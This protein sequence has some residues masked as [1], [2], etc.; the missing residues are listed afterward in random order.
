MPRRLPPA[1]QRIPDRGMMAAQ[2]RLG[3]G[4][5]R[6]VGKPALIRIHPPPEGKVVEDADRLPIGMDTQ[7]HRLPAGQ[8]GGDQGGVEIALA[9]SFSCSRSRRTAAESICGLRPV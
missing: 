4:V 2:A 5:R 1:R 7:Q 3:S 6:T 8:R 9:P